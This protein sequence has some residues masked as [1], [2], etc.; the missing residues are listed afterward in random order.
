M[1]QAIIGAAI[2]TAAALAGGATRAQ[3]AAVVF[4]SDAESASAQPAE[5]RSVSWSVDA[6]LAY[7]SNVAGLD[8]L[9]AA[10]EGLKPSD[11]IFS[12]GVAADV[13]LPVGPDSVFL[14]GS[15]GY[16]FYGRNTILNSQDVHLDGGFDARL[17]RC[18][19]QVTATYTNGQS[20][21]NE[22]TVGVVRNVE[23]DESITL[24]ASC[25]RRVGLIP[26]V[27][28]SDEA[29]HNSNPLQ[30]PSNFNSA[31]ATFG[32]GYAQPMLGVL[33]LYG[34]YDDTEFPNR[35]PEDGYKLY[36]VGVRYDRRLGAR[37]EAVASL[38]Y[39]ELS[40]DLAGDPS[41]NGPTYSLDGT[42]RATGKIKAHV[43]LERLL[44]P[45]LQLDATYAIEQ[46]YLAEAVYAV[47]S[48]VNAT[49][50]VS[51]Q[52]EDYRGAFLAPAVDVTHETLDALYASASLD[53]G[54]RL[55]LVFDVREERRSANLT[56]Y[57]YASTRV[58]LTARAKF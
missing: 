54:R 23:D 30:Q 44:E 14:H 38:S 28:V 36:A 41:F 21:L 45:V 13:V 1:R 25:P 20:N 6:A 57:D 43:R 52:L 3:D 12:P 42:F 40:P 11:D 4:A 26:T 51:E 5:T 50:G 22:L 15:A 27:S 2:A 55:V 37:I 32:I 33:S 58:G 7:D 48:R 24:T 47:N 16:N 18:N 39:S 35:L 9:T 49:I 56:A 31:K 10:K 17:A 8:A 46:T 34:F 29:A 53:L 19:S